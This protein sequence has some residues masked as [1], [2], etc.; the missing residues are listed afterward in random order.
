MF[1]MVHMNIILQKL[2]EGK[3]P[4]AFVIPAF[5]LD[6]GRDFPLSKAVLADAVAAS[7]AEHLDKLACPHCHKFAGKQHF[8]TGSRS[9]RFSLFRTQ[10]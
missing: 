4:L 6:E 3:R 5:D 10:V 9:T 2:K 1:K 8:I 7:K